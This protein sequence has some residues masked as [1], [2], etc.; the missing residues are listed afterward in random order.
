MLTSKINN[1][2]SETRQ[3]RERLVSTIT[4]ETRCLEDLAIG[5]PLQENILVS[6]GVGWG[7]EFW[8]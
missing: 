7:L 2:S 6:R 4:D 1:Q 3:I 5:M 8:L